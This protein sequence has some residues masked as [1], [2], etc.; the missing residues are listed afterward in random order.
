MIFY[1]ES[2]QCIAS[3]YVLY[4][5]IVLYGIKKNVNKARK[6]H[7]SDVIEDVGQ[8]NVMPYSIA[9]YC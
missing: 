1:V 5:Q 7:R 3:K 4:M 8:E 6:H 2:H 9:T